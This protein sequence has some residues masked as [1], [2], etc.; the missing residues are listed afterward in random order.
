MNE[1]FLTGE[2]YDMFKAPGSKLISG[3]LNGETALTIRAEK[4]P[5]DSRYAG[6]MRVM[7]ETQQRR[8]KLRRLGDQL[9]AWYTP[10]A[11]AI[12][13]L[14]WAVTRESHRFLAV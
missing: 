13:L 11:V 2:P 12:A 10:L 3:A 14:A 6:I 9:G 5:V 4:L 1:A 7:E 8:P